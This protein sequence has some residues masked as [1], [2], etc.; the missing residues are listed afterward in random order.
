MVDFAEQR[1]NMVESQV[2]PSDLTDRRITAAM[3]EVCR[4]AYLPSALQGVAYSDGELSLGSVDGALSEREML[5]PRTI[6]QLIQML[7]LEAQDIV[8]LAGTGSGYEAALL[9]HMVQTVVCVESDKGLAEWAETMLQSQHVGNAATVEGALEDGY[10]GE[11]PYDAILINGG[12]DLVPARLLDQLKD[13]GRLAAV[14][15]RDGVTRLVRWQR[16]GERYATLEQNAATARVLP[17]FER[18]ASF[19]F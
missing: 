7:E 2:R 10:A 4:E 6:A 19:V 15:R 8:L 16:D 9:S 12:V 14:R 5:A 11:G 18:E 1:L 17:A 13:G 3:L